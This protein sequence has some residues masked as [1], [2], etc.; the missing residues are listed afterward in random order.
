MF[1]CGTFVKIKRVQLMMNARK[2]E[3]NPFGI[4]VIKYLC[5]GFHQI[6]YFTLEF[7][8]TVI[9]QSLAVCYSVQRGV[10][11]NYFHL[12]CLFIFFVLTRAFIPSEL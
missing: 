3:E 12:I 7:C 6:S 10:T 9:G 4:S 11:C 5:Q 8:V 2:K 1:K